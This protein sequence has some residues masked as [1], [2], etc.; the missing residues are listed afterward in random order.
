MTKTFRED[1]LPSSRAIGP[2]SALLTAREQEVIGLLVRGRANKEIA[3]A[4]SCS[5]RT[6][7]FH[8]SNLLRKLGVSS[9]LELVTQAQPSGSAAAT[10]E[11]PPF[12]VRLFSGVA[13]TAV[14]DTL[15]SLWRAPAT[16]ER[17][18]WHLR[19]LDDLAR[20]YSHGVRCQFMVLPSS[21][22][23]DLLL[24]AKI[25]ADIAAFGGRLRSF[26][27]VALGDMSRRR[28][29]HSIMESAFSASGQTER[30]VLGSS[31]EQGFSHV[32]ET[33]GHSTPTR[34]ELR[35]VVGEISRLLGAGA[36]L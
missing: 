22:A 30:L 11:P 2:G 36:G 5:V 10:C 15:L 6:V 17:W 24:Q 16:L 31:V 32:L 21:R 18:R 35:V 23:P 3:A 13:A 9:R 1:A 14:G 19:L 7:E 27:G 4:L 8:I 12:E 25:E 33:A 28:E 26:V 34:G 29:V 20:S